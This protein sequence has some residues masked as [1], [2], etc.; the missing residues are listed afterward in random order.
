MSVK[1]SVQLSIYSP[2]DRSLTCLTTFKED[3]KLT[4]YRDKETRK[5]MQ[6]LIA[7]NPKQISV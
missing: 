7:I 6:L 3:T 4:V 5:V 2:S 1:M